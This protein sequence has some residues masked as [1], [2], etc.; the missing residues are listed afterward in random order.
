MIFRKGIKIKTDL[1]SVLSQSTRLTDGQTDSFLIAIPRLHSMQ[2]GKNCLK[3]TKQQFF[4]TFKI[5][6]YRN[7]TLIHCSDAAIRNAFRCTSAQIETDRECRLSCERR[8]AR[9]SYFGFA[10]NI[11]HHAEQTSRLQRERLHSP[12]LCSD[13][14][15]ADSSA[16]TV[17]S[18]A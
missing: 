4:Y 6:L 12:Q 17:L 11:V 18:A 2:R 13:H 7:S 3:I 5:H 14:P 1:S 16:G 8:G 15:V 10:C 9:V